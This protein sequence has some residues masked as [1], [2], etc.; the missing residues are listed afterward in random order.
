MNDMAYDVGNPGD[1]G[2]RVDVDLGS[3]NVLRVPSAKSQSTM[4]VRKLIVNGHA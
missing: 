3:L 2:R 1:G 4:R